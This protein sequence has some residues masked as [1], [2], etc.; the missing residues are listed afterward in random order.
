MQYNSIIMTDIPIRSSLC[1]YVSTAPI[2]VRYH[3]GYCLAHV[4]IISYNLTFVVALV[5]HHPIEYSII[6]KLNVASML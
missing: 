4:V 1:R 6:V 3:A 2:V 5:G